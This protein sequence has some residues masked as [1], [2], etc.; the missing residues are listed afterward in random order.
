VAHDADRMLKLVLDT[1]EEGHQAVYEMQPEVGSVG[2]DDSTFENLAI[3][4]DA[5]VVR[6]EVLLGIDARVDAQ[7]VCD[8]TAE[9]FVQHIEASASVLAV[10]SLGEGGNRGYDELVELQVADRSVDL[11][12]IVH[13]ILILAIPIRKIAPGA[14]EIDIAVKFGEEPGDIDPRWAPLMKRKSQD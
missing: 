13:D 11:A 10:D 4:V 14:E 12:S 2:L 6:A 9:S 3:R 7:L 1:L 8:R 5:K